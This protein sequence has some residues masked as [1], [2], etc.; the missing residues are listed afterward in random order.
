MIGLVVGAVFFVAYVLCRRHDP[1]MLRNGVFLTAAIAL[2]GLG[3]LDLLSAWSPVFATVVLLLAG[4]A[5]LAVPVLGVA[6]LWNGVRMFRREGRSLGNMLSFLLG[7]LVFVLPAIVVALIAGAAASTTEGWS[8]LGTAAAVF[9]VVVCVYVAAAFVS[10]SV[11]SIVYARMRHRV[12]PDTI[13]VLGSGLVRGEVPPL[14]RSR[15]DRALRVYEHEVGAGRRPLLVPSGG[16]GDDEP[17]PEGTAMAEYLV[18]NGARPDDV[19]AETASRNTLQNLRLSR[20]VQRAAGRDGSM[21]VVTNNY[22]VLRAAVLAR[23]A[24]LD[25]QV[26]GA[27]TAAYYVPSAFLREFVAVIVEHKWLNCIAFSPFVV[28]FGYAVWESFQL[29]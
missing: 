19:R 23:K 4:L 9:V 21:L 16:Q 7:V 26:I 15:L 18:A 12:V 8:I 25:A 14:L 6:L 2:A 28:L 10:F 5:V 29:R 17:R 20:E 13:V 27:P 3:V 22:H 24:E 1:R 11:Y